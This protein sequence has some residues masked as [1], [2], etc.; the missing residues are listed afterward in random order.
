MNGC[1]LDLMRNL[2]AAVAIGITLEMR[3]S[4]TRR[5]F[6]GT[7]RALRHT[8]RGQRPRKLAIENPPAPS[9]R[10]IK[11]VENL[12]Q[13]NCLPPKYDI[14]PKALPWA[15]ISDVLRV[16]NSSGEGHQMPVIPRRFA[17]SRFTTEKNS[18]EAALGR[19]RFLPNEPKNY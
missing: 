11:L 14:F 2:M 15:G 13:P 19:T 16:A 9:A 10:L 7:P 17:L 12:K 1:N 4:N 6:F 5:R 8:S 3:K 18:R